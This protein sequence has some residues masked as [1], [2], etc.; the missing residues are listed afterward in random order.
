MLRIKVLAAVDFNDDLW[1]KTNEIQN[2]ILKWDLSAE[3]ETLEAPVPQKLPD[4]GLS[5]RRSP[6]HGFCE[7]AVAFRNWTMVK[8]WRHRPL[9]RLGP[10][11]P[12]HPLPQG[13]RVRW[14][15]RR[16]NRRPL[17]P[18][19]HQDVE[20]AFGVLVLDE[21]RRAGVGELEHGDLA[22]D[23]RGDVEQVARVET[24]I[25]W[26]GIV[27]DLNF[28]GGAP[29]SGFVTESTSRPPVI[30]SLTARPRSLDTVETRSTAAS[31]SFLSTTRLLSLLAGMTRA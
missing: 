14:R 12:R 23:L 9:T 30:D 5:V 18:H 4:G 25:E 28:F 8:S 13:E 17:N 16:V 29:E 10:C 26:V 24:D 2:V 15:G 22:F 31:K 19:R 3:F 20:R 1:I 6:A 21:R 27:L 11:G 7:I